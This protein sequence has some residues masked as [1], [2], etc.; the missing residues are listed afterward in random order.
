MD[1]IEKEKEKSEKKLRNLNKSI[2]T[3][4][5]SE[6]SAIDRAPKLETYKQ[7]SELL[8]KVHNTFEKDN[9]YSNNLNFVEQY[10]ANNIYEY[11]IC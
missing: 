10:P 6:I 4:I 5:L 8:S 2:D 7:F 11:H 1:M 3:S 9:E